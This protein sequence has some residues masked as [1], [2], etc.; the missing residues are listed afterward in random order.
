MK[1]TIPVLFTSAGNDGFQAVFKALNGTVYQCIAVDAR[2]D[3][4]GLY[5]VKQ[6]H[7]VPLRNSR[8][9][10]PTLLHIAKEKGAR[11]LL[12]LS[13]DDQL[14]F[15]QHLSHFYSNGIKVLVSDLAAVRIA[16][17]KLALAEFAQQNS[18]PQP[19]FITITSKDQFE[20]SLAALKADDNPIVL[21]IGRTTGAKGVKIV[22]PK[23]D[24]TRRLFGRDNIHISLGELKRWLGALEEWPAFVLTEYLPGNEYSVD[25]FLENRRVQVGV[26]RKRLQTLYG[27]ALVAEIVDE[28]DVLE[29]AIKIA[30]RLGL[31]YIANIQIKRDGNGSPMLMEVNPRIPGSIDLT[32][33]AGCN[34]PLWALQIAS[35]Q[36]VSYTQ[37][38][39]GLKMTRHWSAIF[40]QEWI[41]SGCDP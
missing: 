37:A 35:G 10:I 27:L 34:M 16:N 17:D 25:L 20:P 28:P 29:L 33:A 30:E 36:R 5:L 19:R 13:T 40:T 4:Y 32:V 3:A 7:V 15:A 26:A 31:N 21:K 39:I 22:H 38:H 14:F 18:I 1:T 9:F 6:R 11:F 24:V 23:M 41:K 8:D 2:S 12:P